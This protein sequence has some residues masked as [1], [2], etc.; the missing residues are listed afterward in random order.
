[1]ILHLVLDFIYENM[2][3]YRKHF[4]VSK[5]F[6]KV[7]KLFEND[8]YLLS[9]VNEVIQFVEYDF[10]EVKEIIEVD[11][12]PSEVVGRC[13]TCGYK[14]EDLVLCS[15]PDCKTLFPSW[16]WIIFLEEM[17]EL[18]DRVVY[19]VEGFITHL[20]KD[21]C[22]L[23]IILNSE[24]RD[25]D[26]GTIVGCVVYD[27]L[28][29][30]NRIIRLG[31]I[32]YIDKI[33]NKTEITVDFS[34]VKIPEWLKAGK[35]IKITN[36]ENLVG[37][38]LQEAW[39]LEAQRNFRGFYEIIVEILKSS[40]S[41]ESKRELKDNLEKIISNARRAINLLT[42]N[43]KGS[44]VPVDLNNLK[45]L[46][47]KFE[48]DQSQIDVV[49]RILGL[50]DG[51]MLIVVGPPGTGKTE[52]IAKSAYELAKRGEKVL[53]T[54]HT[55]V[56]VN[57]ALEKLA[58]KEDIKI[59]RVGRPEKISNKLK[60]IMLSKVRFER[61]SEDLIKKIRKL[62]EEIR[63]LKRNLKELN[64]IEEI[65]KNTKKINLN[66]ALKKIDNIDRTLNVNSKLIKL[67]KEIIK[68][69][70]EIYKKRR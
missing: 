27:P 36:A 35:K 22:V 7:Q 54:S 58:D 51:E 10:N 57:N 56:A 2:D 3:K 41:D 50:K 66:E 68:I 14:S 39:I 26:E 18:K 67:Q 59:V 42:S 30:R 25:F 69:K 16:Q 52:V 55:N 12:N 29:K 28:E 62:E 24:P 45:S 19:P 65:L 17:R 5:V 61:A 38:H 1:M 44:I 40:L 32:M 47:G 8:N 43:K 33:D 9:I 11:L 60:E 21:S 31:K 6:E 23:T 49:K 15:N 53:I 13:E 20:N 34:E 63:C 46:N 37:Y 64:S 70:H 4:N 48:L